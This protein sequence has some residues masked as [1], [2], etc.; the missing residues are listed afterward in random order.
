MDLKLDN[1]WENISEIEIETNKWME[2]LYQYIK[3]K[4]VKEIVIPGTHD[5]GTYSCT[6]ERGITPQSDFPSF[7]CKIPCLRPIIL[8][9]VIDQNYDIL[10]QL[11]AGIRY[12]DFRV[13]LSIYD[14][15]FRVHHSLYGDEYE[16]IFNQI[17][18]FISIN[19]NE[20]IIINFSHFYW[21]KN[22]NMTLDQHRSLLK[23]ME[24]CIGKY[25]LSSDNINMKIEDILKTDKRI[26][27]IYNGEFD[28][29]LTDLINQLNV[30]YIVNGSCNLENKWPNSQKITDLINYFN[31]D[32]DTSQYGINFF[33]LK[34]V[35]T[36][37]KKSVFQGVFLPCYYPSSTREL[38]EI[39]NP[40]IHKW[41][42]LNKYNVNIVSLDWIDHSPDLI[43]Y[44]I[45][46]N[47]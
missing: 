8:N 3:H 38:A 6:I 29:N 18:E 19:K 44:L 15:K 14:N 40:S 31:N 7:L 17:L 16:N 34:A 36:P 43:L 45:G 5:S 26:I 23:I 12:F 24:S 21:K 47:I 41:L 1:V 32:E 30:N 39:C 13:S 28:E 46:K 22:Q 37:N 42:K 35:L 10:S 33:Q 25:L 27:L 4:T 20:I 9:F 11:N 2:I